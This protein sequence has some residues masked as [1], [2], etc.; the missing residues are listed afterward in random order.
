MSQYHPAPPPPPPPP[1]QPQPYAYWLPASPEEPEQVSVLKLF[2]NSDQWRSQSHHTKELWE[3]GMRTQLGQE[4]GEAQET[5]SFVDVRRV[6]AGQKTWEKLDDSFS[7]RE[8]PA[9]SLPLSLP[10]PLPL[11]FEHT[12]HHIAVL[13]A[14]A[15]EGHDGVRAQGEGGGQSGHQV[16]GLGQPL[17]RQL[18]GLH[19]G[20]VAGP[21]L[22]LLV[23][24]GGAGGQG[25]G[26][27]PCARGSC[28]CR[29]W[30]G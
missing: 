5:V 19:G 15:V 17:A 8:L 25:G 12:Q 24:L 16:E 6:L 3:E 23:R 1:P 9:L 7:Q 2:Y 27:T 21:V 20:D 4:G 26:G 13:H 30:A 11:T 18:P 29:C 10:L 14:G 22:V 28:R